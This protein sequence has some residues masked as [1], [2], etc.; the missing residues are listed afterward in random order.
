[1]IAATTFTLTNPV[2][3]FMTVETALSD[4][5]LTRSVENAFFNLTITL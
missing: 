2:S 3:I 5:T 1:M 4:E